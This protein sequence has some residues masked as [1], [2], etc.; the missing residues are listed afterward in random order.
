[1]PVQRKIEVSF[2]F[3]TFLLHALD[4]DKK[5]PDDAEVTFS[6]VENPRTIV[7]GLSSKEWPESDEMET[8]ILWSSMQDVKRW[9]HAMA[10]VRHGEV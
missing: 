10:L 4:R 5:L 9:K 3:M 7:L 1:M 6:V 8:L 2:E